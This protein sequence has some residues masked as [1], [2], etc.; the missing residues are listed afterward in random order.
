MAASFRV[1]GLS[2][3]HL[4][5][6]VVHL[7]GS[8]LHRLLYSLEPVAPNMSLGTS[9]ATHPALKEE[10]RLPACGERNGALL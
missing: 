2:G 4:V 7:S 6:G 3:L 9:G 5:A 1:A 10:P 8:M